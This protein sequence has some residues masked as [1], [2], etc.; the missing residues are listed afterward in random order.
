MDKSEQTQ[1]LNI[2][3]IKRRTAIGVVTLTSRTFILQIIGLIATFILT[4]ILDPATY[5]IFFVISAV[6][7]FLNYFSDI[8]LAAALIQKKEEPTRNDFVTVFTIQ[9]LLVITGVSISFIVSPLIINFYKLGQDSLFL[10]R[11][12]ILAFLLS[13]F[14][15]IPSI[16]LERKLN[17]HKL[18]VPQII[19]TTLFYTVAIILALKGFGVRS[20]GWAALI[21]GISGTAVLYLIAPWKPGLTLNFK[22]AKQFLSF[23]VPYQINQFLA[24]VKDDLLTIFLGKWLTF[25]QVGFVGWAKKWAEIALRL[26]MD[27]IIRVTFPAFSRLQHEAKLLSKAIEKSLV[28]LS[29]LTFPIAIGM[30]FL[31][32]PFIEVVPKY[33][34]WEPALFSFYL[35]TISS[36]LATLSSPLVNALNAIRKIRYTFYLMILWTILTWILVPVLIGIFSFNGVAIAAVIIGLTSFVPVFILKKTISFSFFYQIKN[37]IFATIGMSLFLFVLINLLQNNLLK[38]IFG[39]IGGGCVYFIIIYLLMGKELISYTQLLK[40]RDSS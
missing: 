4:I 11:A 29:L 31:I 8:G 28:F 3:E 7:N 23:G 12:L 1:N 2:F 34:K 15:T 5:G 17:F 14:K 37:P 10:F 6:V 33:L 38:I 35:F 21:R 25:T 19:E 32:R 9:E 24:L 30:M 18:V 26:I 40:N 39:I 20:F 13:S 16:I 22:N 36:V 27:N